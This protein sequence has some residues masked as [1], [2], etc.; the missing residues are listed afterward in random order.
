MQY[1][2]IVVFAQAY[3]HPSIGFQEFKNKEACEVA[4]AEVRRLWKEEPR[5]L[6]GASCVPK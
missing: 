1:I 6:R 3:G 5:D 2:L 4:A